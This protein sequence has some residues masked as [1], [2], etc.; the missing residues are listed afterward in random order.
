MGEKIFANE[1]T[2]KGLTP[3][4]CKQL[5]HLNMNNKKKSN[6]KMGRRLK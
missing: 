6:Q 5:M 1:A 3:K 2:N 4:I